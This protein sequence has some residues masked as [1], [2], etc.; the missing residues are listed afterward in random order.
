[1]T[2]ELPIMFFKAD[3]T[4]YARITKK[5]K[6]V[7]SGQGIS[8]YLRPSFVSVDLVQ[9]GEREVAFS[10]NET[11]NDK[12]P[13]SVQ[14]SLLYEIEDPEKVLGSYNF[15]IDP[16]TKMYLAQG[17]EDLQDSLIR[18]IGGFA[19]EIVQ[20]RELEKLLIGAKDI[21]E[22]IAA[23]FE[24]AEKIKRLGL[25]YSELQITNVSTTRDIQDALAA[26]YKEQ[27]LT[28]QQEA[29]YA[30]RAAAVEQER[31]ISENE[32]ESRLELAKRAAEVIDVENANELKKSEMEAESLRR[33]LSTYTGLDPELVRAI[34]LD[35]FGQNASS[36]NSLTIGNELLQPK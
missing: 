10:F 1:M 31:E 12:Q 8:C 11:T 33:V 2:I 30:R 24:K 17:S 7:Q 27:L 23:E 35:R 9:M 6:V 21:Q 34:A 14:G 18:T 16:R 26:R 25:A 20:T 5:G 15:T 19:R 13:L 28:K 29:Q 3:P 32:L 36:L 4:E 22:N